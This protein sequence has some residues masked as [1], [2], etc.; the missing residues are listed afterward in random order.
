ML[1]LGFS[2]APA[3]RA[4]LQMPDPKEMSGIPR[5][6]NDLPSGSISVRVIRGELSNNIAN[7]PV[8]LH[9]GDKIQTV[10]TDD[11]GR[12]QFDHVPAG[13]TVK[14]VTVVEGERLES[15]EFPAPAEGGIRL[16]LVATDK[17]KAAKA[18]AEAS[19]PAIVGEVGFSDQSR[20]VIEPGDE[21]VEVYYLLT[22][23]N[24]AHAPVNPPS[25]FIFDMPKE[26]VGTAV[27]EGSSPR[28]SATG[29][30]VR[31]QG[32]FP[33]GETI[34]QVAC[35]LPV[36]SGSLQI[37]QRFPVALPQLMVIAKKVEDMRLTSPAIATEQ[38]MSRDGATYI[39]AGGGAV[40]AGQALTLT[41]S[42][43]PHHSTTPRVTALSVAFGIVVLGVWASS[44][45]VDT[46]ARRDERKRLIARREKLFQELLRLEN[47]RRNGRGDRSRQ[48]SRREELLAALEQVYG[49]LDT[50]DA[51][52]E[53]ADRSGAAR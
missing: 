22:I 37:S 36:T 30:R 13:S 27:L 23:V 1:A 21:A 46:S 5:P 16:M 18:A 11:A 33:P 40:G 43:L 44:R 9:I 31:V 45:P 28:A 25:T 15:Q 2:L 39:V 10:N 32:P 19:A 49:A 3:L 8:E 7:H 42:G 47:D 41:L 12:A 24:S 4:Q 20:V 48:S 52:P 35:S 29:T 6:V 17:E 50:D 34:V 51:A 53:L 26:A 38:E 14:A